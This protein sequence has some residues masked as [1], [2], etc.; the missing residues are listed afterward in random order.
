MNFQNIL[1]DRVRD[2]KK[3]NAMMNL[4]KTLPYRKSKKFQLTGSG[5]FTDNFDCVFWC[6]DLNFRLEQ[7]REV[8]M[9]E[10]EGGA[11]VL[12]FDQLNYLKSEGFIFRGYS[13]DTVKF[14][15]T[16]KY[17]PGTNQFDTSSKK[18]VPSYTGWVHICHVVVVI[19]DLTEKFNFWLKYVEFT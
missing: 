18:R 16:Y 8:V 5:D 11:S 6:G 7:S 4:P 3:I 9:R 13:E 19:L 15:P 12:D 14:P 2:L 10:V 1:R 17:D